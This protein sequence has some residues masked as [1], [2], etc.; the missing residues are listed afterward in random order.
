L[1]AKSIVRFAV[2]FVASCLCALPAMGQAP[3]APEYP[4]KP[5]GLEKLAREILKAESQGDTA[6]FTT[7]LNRLLL[8]NSTAWYSSVFDEETATSLAR[9]YEA[10]RAQY[11]KALED[12]FLRSQQEHF[13]EV[14][15]LR[16]E[17]SCDDASGEQVFGVLYARNAPVP[18]YELRLRKG[19]SFRRLWALAY[20]D[21]GFRYVGSLR[22]P[23]RLM[24]VS[25]SNPSPVREITHTP[26]KRL[27]LSENVA[28][29]R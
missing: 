26:G 15:A 10:E 28:Q 1:R 19:N 18:I 21:G 6:R 29:A 25:R 4:D 8:S 2:R 16:F 7:L 17:N 27:T 24:E 20:V 13:T 23:E 14:Q 3:A 5:A 12:F 22:P 9:R 11:P